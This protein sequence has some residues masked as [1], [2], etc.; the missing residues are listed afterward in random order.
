MNNQK[1]FSK[2]A[3]IAIIAIVIAIAGWW[4]YR[5]PYTNIFPIG[6]ITPPASYTPN[7]AAGWQTYRNQEAGFEIKYPDSWFLKKD[8]SD[9]SVMVLIAS[10]D[11]QYRTPGESIATI[12]I[13]VIRSERVGTSYFS[14]SND[15]V[16][17]TSEVVIDG[18]TGKKNTHNLG[19]YYSLVITNKGLTYDFY[20]EPKR[21]VQG[22]TTDYSNTINQ[23]LATFKFI[24]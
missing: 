15:D 4:F 11:R 3:A 17:S 6:L 7:P 1:G 18:V 22:K 10:D 2:I 8:I 21:L 16:A 14:D 5:R 13:S 19:D 23:I 20:V 24:K 9:Q 12:D